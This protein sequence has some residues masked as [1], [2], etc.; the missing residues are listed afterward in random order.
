M[1]GFEY[2]WDDRDLVRV[3][4]TAVEKQGRRPFLS[5]PHTVLLILAP[6]FSL[7]TYHAFLR[8]ASLSSVLRDSPGVLIFERLASMA[9]RMAADPP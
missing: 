5:L 6:T 3:I 4:L 2:D 8:V 1:V 7:S 9:S